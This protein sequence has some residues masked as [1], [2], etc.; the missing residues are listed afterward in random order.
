[1]QTDTHFWSYLAHFFSEWETFQTKVVYEL[2]THILCSEGNFENAN[3]IE[4]GNSLVSVGT[5]SGD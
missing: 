1:M 4:L 3:A 5:P 2:K